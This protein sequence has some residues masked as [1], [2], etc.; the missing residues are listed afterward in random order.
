[1]M[2]FQ[3]L[4]LLQLVGFVVS[5]SGV[6]FALLGD[7]GK[8]GDQQTAVAQAL[9]SCDA[10][11]PYDFVVSLG[12]NFYQD[13][14]S[15]VTD[16][17]WKDTWKD[18]Y[19][20][21]LAKGTKWMTIL[22]NHDYHKVESPAAELAF[23]YNDIWTIPDLFF[24]KYFSTCD[25][26]E[27]AA[28][29]DRAAFR[30]SCKSGLVAM[31]FL[32]TPIL[33]PGE[34][35]AVCASLLTLYGGPS[36][37]AA[38]VS[39]YWSWTDSTLA[40]LN[41]DADV[42]WLL[43]VGHY[44]IYTTGHHGDYS[45]SSEGGQ[46]PVAVVELKNKLLPLL[47]RHG[48]DAY[49][50][51]H[52]HLLAVIRT[53]DGAVAPKDEVTQ[54]VSGSGAKLDDVKY[55]TIA[56]ATVP[57]TAADAGFISV[58]ISD[59]CSM[60]INV[61]SLASVKAEPAVVFELTQS[62]KRGDKF[63]CG[64]WV[65]PI[66]RRTTADGGGAGDEPKMTGFLL[67]TKTAAPIF[68]VF[69]TLSPV[70]TLY[71]L[72]APSDKSIVHSLPLLPYSSMTVN[73]LLW[74]LY[75]LL[76]GAPPVW[77]S[78]LVAL[79]MG[80]IYCVTFVWKSGGVHSTFF[81]RLNLPLT[82]RHHVIASAAIMSLGVLLFGVKSRL[83]L[84]LLAN[85]VCFVLFTSPLSSIARIVK[86]GKCKRGEI[87]LPFAMFQ[88]ANCLLWSYYGTVAIGDPAVYLPN[89]FGCFCALAQ[90]VTMIKYQETKGEERDAQAL[91]NQGDLETDAI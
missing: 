13:G 40:S 63:G 89:Y 30:A 56:G 1:M 57:F 87:P 47:T 80:C 38:K 6:S 41:T 91:A 83:A 85:A 59:G 22:G 58:K 65:A 31:V 90:M 42:S 39:E 27:V 17:Q 28:D 73:G 14:V 68:S 60:A 61:T 64:K 66:G 33:A 3:L 51:G 46:W 29:S 84:A 19:S 67:F 77:S 37:V 8:A 75:G 71:A 43:V 26:S 9:T 15:S 25:G 44:P 36:G 4:V 76:I 16:K 48:V 78:N 18:V 24:V 62:P 55:P 53:A 81:I 49:M 82:W 21:L 5:S 70:P 11:H 12:D 2:T 79:L 74:F 52:D 32:D 50:S 54:L 45:R 10:A 23:K 7:W 72:P 34:S 86:A 20:E 69:L 88:M 35:D